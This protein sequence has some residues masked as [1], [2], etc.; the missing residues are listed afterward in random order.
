MLYTLV[1][2]KEIIAPELISALK[3]FPAWTVTIG[4]S[5]TSP[6][7]NWCVGDC[8]PYSF[9]SVSLF[10]EGSCSLKDQ[11]HPILRKSLTVSPE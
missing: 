4:Q 11:I 6:I 1:H 3:H 9:E 10:E 5:E 2:I 7:V 8:S